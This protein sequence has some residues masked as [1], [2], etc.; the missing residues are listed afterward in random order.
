[1]FNNAYGRKVAKQSM[2]M[3]EAFIE[4]A[5]KYA[6]PI[7]IGAKSMRKKTAG[8]YDNNPI[9][10]GTQI[11]GNM[12]A[13]PSGKVQGGSIMSG[14]SDGYN[15]DLGIEKNRKG[16]TSKIKDTK[17]NNLWEEIEKATG[18]CCESRQMGGNVVD[19]F[20]HDLEPIDLH[21]Q[22]GGAFD[23][24]NMTKTIKN[25]E[26]IIPKLEQVARESKLLEPVMKEQPSGKLEAVKHIIKNTSEII[27]DIAPVLKILLEMKQ[28][29]GK[30]GGVSGSFPEPVQLLEGNYAVGAK[31]KIHAVREKKD[32]KDKPKRAKSAWNLF[33]EKMM[34]Q[35][36]GT[37]RETLKM[38]KDRN[39]WK[40]K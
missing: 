3:D 1:M 19:S 37:M 4:N 40:K 21:F 6:S 36:G 2:A 5:K 11:W 16:A 12:P 23:K 34:K 10:S 8:S 26:H 33:V 20:G 32:K 7:K 22:S 39:M 28:G 27:K 14:F 24:K 38:I 17:K 31:K 9:P 13:D 35:S 25:A 30:S 15:N 29:K 18:G